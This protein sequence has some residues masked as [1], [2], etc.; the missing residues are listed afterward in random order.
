MSYFSIRYHFWY[1]LILMGVVILVCIG[2]PNRSYGQVTDSFNSEFSAKGP[3]GWE[4]F[5]QLNRL[6]ELTRGVRTRQFSSFDRMGGN[7][8]D[9]FTGKFSCLRLTEDG[10]CVIAE[11]TGAGE[12][13][14]IW[15]TRNGGDVSANGTLTI[16]LDG[17]V[18]IQA[19]LQKIVNGEL[20]PPFVY[21]LVADAD[22]S[23]GGTYIKVPMPYRESMV[24]TTENRPRFYILTYQAFASAEGVETFDPSE[25]ARDV[26]GMLRQAG[27]DDPKGPQK[28]AKTL[29]K[30][31]SLSAGQSITL[32]ELNGPGMITT[33]RLRI[34]Q[35]INPKPT[36]AISDDGRAF[37]GSSTF[38]VSIDPNNEGVR[39]TRR[40]DAGVAH[41]YAR[42]LVDGKVVTEWKPLPAMGGHQW[43]N[44]S[45][46][47]PASVTTGKSQVTITNKFISSEI[48][49]NAFKYWV[50]SKIMVNGFSQIAWMSALDLL[51][52]NRH[53]TIR[54]KTKTG[55]GEATIGILLKYP[56][57]GKPPCEP[58]GLC[59]RRCICESLSMEGRR[60]ILQ[61]VCF[62][63]RVW[64]SVK[65]ARC[66]CY[67]YPKKWMV[68]IVV[69]Y[70]I[71]PGSHCNLDQRFGYRY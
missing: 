31:F 40:L 5:R 65:F 33:L 69:A 71:S 23:S 19:P 64:A 6:P 67:G 62:S 49:F 45:V 8:H 41:Q 48:D 17:K 43:H 10:R 35:I 29:S 54:L 9:G 47:L 36:P 34:P 27:H 21:P 56:L 11:A 70:A 66:F 30:S 63:A 13:T 1:T 57:N 50:E 55:R 26:L 18:V 32:A 28:D 53:I 37:T 12:I 20:G 52:V 14:S 58:L 22:Q 42:V 68:F 38:T 39:L 44:Q 61:S 25:E 60:W 59:W 51:P 15:F 3:V 46:I 16:K 2:A 4:I 7:T 24:V